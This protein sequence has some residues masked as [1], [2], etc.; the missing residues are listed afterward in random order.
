MLK[1]TLSS[2]KKINLNLKRSSFLFNEF[3]KTTEKYKT[4]DRDGTTNTP[5]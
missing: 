3:F 4:L 2:S 5:Q 1:K